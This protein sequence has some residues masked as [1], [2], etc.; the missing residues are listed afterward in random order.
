MKW[1]PADYHASSSAQKEWADEL[2]AKLSLAGDERVLDLGCG[3]GKVTARIADELPGGTVVGVDL[4]QEMIEFAREHFPREE[5]PNLSFA[6]ADARELSFAGAFDVVFSNATL[7]WVVDHK[8]VLASISRAL[9]PGGRMLAQ[10]AGRGNAAGIL[11]VLSDMLMESR[12]GRYFDG[13][14]FPYGFHGPEEYRGWLADAGLRPVR[15]ELFEKDMVQQGAEGLAGW[16][17]TTWMPYTDRVPEH[18][19]AEFVDEIVGRY[20]LLFPPDSDGQ[21]HVKMVRLEVEAGKG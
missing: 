1:D 2:L 5:H 16:V 8:P 15:L 12:W 4:S 11:A 6:Q 9:V 17:R 14:E 7:H 20:T 18:L 10:M 13:F 19:R 21:V 3:D